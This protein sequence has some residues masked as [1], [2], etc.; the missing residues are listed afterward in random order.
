MS[1][2]ITS[3]KRAFRT[4]LEN[5]K[6]RFT[7]LQLFTTS[8]RRS[9][10]DDESFYTSLL[11]KS[12]HRNHLN[13]VHTR[14]YINGLHN[15]G[16]IITKFIHVSSKLK[17][18]D[19]ARQVFDEF[20]DRYVFLWNAII[21]GYSIHNMPVKVLETY[22]TMQQAF[23]S[24]DK[25]T[26]PLVLKAC[27]VVPAARYGQAVHAQILRHGFEDVVV[28]N[29][30]LSF[31]VKCGEN[32]RVR[33][34]F[35]GLSDKNVVSW[36]SII[37]GLAQNGQPDEALRIFK[38]MRGSDV[39]PDWIALV[40]VLKAYSDVDELSQGKCIHGIVI[41]TGYELE[42]DLQISLT[43]LYAK[44][45]EVTAAKTLFD[46]VKSDD[47]ILWNAMISGFAKNGHANEALELFTEMISRKIKPDAVTLQS[48]VLASAQLGSLAQAKQIGKYVN[49]SKFRDDIIVCTALIDM[50]V[51]CGSLELARIVFD[52][53][54]DKD[55]VV[56]S[57]MIMGY[58]LHGWGREAIN[59]FKEMKGGG[60]RPNDVT[61]L[62]LITACSHSG[63]VNE[64]W[65]FF[66]SMKDYGVEPHQKHYAGMVDLLGRAGY[67]DKAR[68]FITA[69]PVEPGVSVWGALLSA[70]RVH[71]R[72]ALGEYAAERLFSL[73]PLNTGH[74]VQLSN[75]YASA[76]R[77]D[78]VEK[79][80]VLM[81][82]KGLTKHYGHS[83][84]EIKGKLE[85][86]RM[87]DSSHPRSGEIYKKLEWLEMRLLESGFSPDTESALHDLDKEDKE[88]I[89]CN[90]SERLAIAYGLI[91]TS[92]GT[93]L[94]ITKNLRSCVNCHLATKLISK[95]VDR[96]IVV[97]DANRFHHFKDGACSCGDYW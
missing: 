74:H 46:R 11:E 71:L 79:V 67:L 47:V 55:V 94:R 49:N 3:Q 52:R 65:E 53:I 27:G 88:A 35:D 70:C 1:F 21:K 97:R 14:L 38:D 69:M 37:S 54:V 82:S 62:G 61:F 34:I 48:S 7:F 78:G 75:L 72:V 81:K 93:M 45:G 29:S 12:T 30:L 32:Y 39:R 26:F 36:T 63:L 86:F 19:Y 66:N 40:S 22:S 17:E 57:A 43:S 24:P 96:E 60:V 20:P 18:I 59:L 85:A 76:R 5:S 25:F 9:I 6:F 13:Q 91:S 23:V 15:N 56:W 89:L 10:I 33:I 51:K 2:F 64:G 41:K 50:Y 31:Y 28:Q 87:G 80:R 4:P 95:L 58:G 92:P 73:D 8:S 84:I 83:V 42:P 68:D 77:W 90:H 16:F 44:C